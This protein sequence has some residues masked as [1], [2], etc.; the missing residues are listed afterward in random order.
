MTKS[1]CAHL[2]V[3]SEYSLL[4]GACK[5]GRLAE[6]AAAFGQPA[7]GL[8]DHGVM[9]GA[10]E[11]HQACA[12]HGIKPIIGCEVYLVED[13]TASGPGRVERNHLTL[14]AASD[15]GYRNLVR[16]SS[17]GFLEGLR[18]GKPT[19]DMGQL[20]S[21][22]EGLIALTGCLAS[23]FCQ[24]LLED[25]PDDARAH[26][27]ELV[28]ALGRENVYFEVQKNGLAEQ[29]KCNEGI[30]RIA[31]E[32]GGALV[33]TGDVHYLRREDYDHHTALLCV[34]TK[35]T[36]AQP[37]MT[38]ATNEFYL[39]DSDEM[40][41]AFAEWPE[42]MAS[43]IEIAERCDVTLELGRQLIPRYPTPGGEPVGEYLRAR[44]LEGLA[45]RYGDPPPA[46]ALERMEMELSV[47]ERMG[48]DSYF[49]IVWDFVAYA[50]RSGIAVG[51]GR[52]SAAGSM[53]A[54][55]LQITDVDPLRYGLLFERFLNPRA[56]VDARHRHRLL[57]ARPRARDALRDRQVRPR[58]GRADRHLRQDVPARGHPRRRA[59]ARPGLRRRRPPRQADPR[60][61]HGPRTVVRGVPR[62]RRAAAQGL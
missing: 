10:V 23:R 61:D 3:H 56:R 17:A 32:M 1:V 54:Y 34:Q 4:D 7:L 43:T 8:T 31:R 55:C 35:S 12:T 57:R 47:I 37:K 46:E 27:D 53:V 22:S 21:H 20:A 39:R 29:D 59:R 40:V 11:L 44:V 25:R 50:K 30:V 62:A 24:R 49:L 19:V 60:P 26:A 36:L 15:D 42:A 45:L 16:L 18:R 58:V 52:G 41:A 51:P 28:N 6:R 2:H 38:F 13:H 33:G 14:L 5:V 48:F 9:N